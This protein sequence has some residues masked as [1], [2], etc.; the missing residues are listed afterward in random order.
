M[1][2]MLVKREQQQLIDIELLKTTEE[3]SQII[4]YRNV[5]TLEW[6]LAIVLR[7]RCGYAYVSTRNEKLWLPTKFIK[8]RSD[9]ENLLSL[10][11]ECLHK[12]NK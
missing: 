9:R 10:R 2:L 6:K 1:C 12:A 5:L 7:W 3:L 11:H 4:D 8:I